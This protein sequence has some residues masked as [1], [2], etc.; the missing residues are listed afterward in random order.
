MNDENVSLTLHRVVHAP[1]ETVYD[2][3]TDPAVVRQWMAPG[4]MDG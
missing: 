4:T 1:L 3:W 2:A